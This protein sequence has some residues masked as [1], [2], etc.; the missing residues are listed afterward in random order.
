MRNTGH[1]CLN[2][3]NHLPGKLELIKKNPIDKKN[4]KNKEIQKK[5][6]KKRQFNFSLFGKFQLGI[7]IAHLY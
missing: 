5:T 1:Q 6:Q 4:K 2:Q 7:L 3:A